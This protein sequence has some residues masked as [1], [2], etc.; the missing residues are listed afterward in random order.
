MARERA[1]EICRF[2][3]SNVQAPLSPDSY[4]MNFDDQQ[5]TPIVLLCGMSNEVGD[6]PIH[7]SVSNFRMIMKL[8]GD[9]AGV[10]RGWVADDVC[11]VAVEGKKDA[12]KFLRFVDQNLIG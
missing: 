4:A 10:L 11:K 6:E 5:Q 1:I 12:F 2:P 8:D 9:D 7:Q 3:R